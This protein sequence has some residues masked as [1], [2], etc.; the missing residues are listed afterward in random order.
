[1]GSQ[2]IV[3]RLCDCVSEKVMPEIACI[4]VSLANLVV[5]ASFSVVIL[6]LRYQG[7]E[8]FVVLG[9]LFSMVTLFYVP[10][11][12]SALFLRLENKYPTLTVGFL[13]LF[14][15]AMGGPGIAQGDSAAVLFMTAISLFGICF[16]DLTCR[17]INEH[18]NWIF[19][20]FIA[21]SVIGFFCFG[22]EK[23]QIGFLVSTALYMFIV[24]IPFD[25]G[26]RVLKSA[27]A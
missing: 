17:V 6:L 27:E 23:A 2:D 25:V 5:I 4:A 20:Q 24:C 12:F 21:I 16:G 7:D 3:E 13:V 26:L 8:L 11:V 9:S 15:A 22:A 1:M 19:R 18:E 10:I 14:A